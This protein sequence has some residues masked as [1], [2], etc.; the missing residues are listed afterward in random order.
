MSVRPTEFTL[1]TLRGVKGFSTS[2][3]AAAEAG[4]S[5]STLARMEQGN[6]ES[7]NAREAV[8]KLYDLSLAQ[9]HRHIDN[10]REERR[11]K[12]LEKVGA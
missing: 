6:D 3:E 7:L 8:A 9:L 4:I 12:D 11:K 2:K 5:A 1:A 10:S